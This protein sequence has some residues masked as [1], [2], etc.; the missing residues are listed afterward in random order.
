MTEKELCFYIDDLK[1]EN[2]TALL[3]VRIHEFSGTTIGG[4]HPSHIVTFTCNPPS[5]WN[6]SAQERIDA[7][8]REI[9]DVLRSRFITD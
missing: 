2:V 8:F 3:S 6:V 9:A 1:K 7:A 4:A 5:G